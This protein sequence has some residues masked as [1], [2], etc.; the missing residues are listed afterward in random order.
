MKITLAMNW[1]NDGTVANVVGDA[2]VADAW[3]KYLLR[4]D[5]VEE[6]RIHSPKDGNVIYDTDVVIH[7]WPEPGMLMHPTAKNI[8]YIQNA[9]GPEFHPDGTVGVFKSVAD[10][11]DGYIYPSETLM[12]N[13]GRAGL[14]LPFGVDH[15]E[16]TYQPDAKYDLPVTFVGS[17]IRGDELN[18][19][20]LLPAIPHGLKIWGGPY[21]DPRLQAVHQGKLLQGEL[22]KLYSSSR[23]SLNVTHAEHS[24]N[25][26][27][28]SRIY[29]ILACG[30]TVLSDA[31]CEFPILF[32]STST[33]FPDDPII[34]ESEAW[35]TVI[36]NA[37]KPVIFSGGPSGQLA[38]ERRQSRRDFI[39]S[40]HTYAHRMADLMKFLGEIV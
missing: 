27:T 39:L 8:L 25:G 33:D 10:R 22:P 2:L 38:T 34:S 17:D 16:F 14:V 40:K 23:C 36:A 32:P 15:E 7:F 1:L 5:D 35:E 31:D 20:Y 6:V 4:R 19:R 24:K 3:K 29:E 37:K 11:F 18:N 28:N 30:G 13:C 21:R 9:F 26:V 12:R